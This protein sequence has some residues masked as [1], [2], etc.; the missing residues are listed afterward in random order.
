MKITA[1]RLSNFQCFGPEPTELMLGGLTY[2]LG[3]NGS[4]KTAVLEA[5]SRMFSALPT[6]RKV[7][8]DDF[9]VPI[10]KSPADIQAGEP[11]LWLE[12]DV[13]FPEAGDD[14]QHA[15]VPPNF[16]HMAIDGAGGVPR[17]RVRLTAT[18]AL[19]GFIDEKIEYVLEA[20]EAGKPIRRAD[21]SRYDRAHIEVH[22]LP[23]RRDPADHISYTTASLIGRTLRAA[24][25]T[26]ERTKI[27]ELSAEITKSLVGNAA[28]GSIGVRL[29]DEWHGLHNGT[30]FKDQTAC[31]RLSTPSSRWKSRKTASRRS[32]SAESSASCKLRLTSVICRR[33]SLRMRPH[34]CA[35]LT[36]TR[37]A[38]CD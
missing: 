7:R 29:T 11:T 12:V 37:S 15:S 5:L 1:L 33:S 28:V 9:H 32:I 10:D 14:T 23:A 2:V 6:Q 30:H 35:V 3:P 20:D 13:G 27:S 26:K 8:V 17:I 34:C 16:A 31:V 19:D 24:D 36:L 22:Y 25:W 18:L 38:S 21:M 4:G